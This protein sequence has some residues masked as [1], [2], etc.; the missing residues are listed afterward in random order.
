[1]PEQEDNGAEDGGDLVG[2]LC[3]D[4]PQISSSEALN[5]LET[6]RSFFAQADLP[7]LVDVSNV[8]FKHLSKLRR[9]NFMIIN[10]ASFSQ[11][12]GQVKLNG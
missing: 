4:P 12:L 6:L 1:M 2:E 5:T 3:L 9:Q 8:P 10:H 11:L 7:P